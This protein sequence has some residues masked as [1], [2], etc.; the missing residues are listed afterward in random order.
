MEEKYRNQL[1]EKDDKLKELRKKEK[2]FQRIEKL[3]SKEEDINRKLKSD[4]DRMK[5]QKVVGSCQSSMKC[6]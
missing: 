4:I 3:K 5:T 6:I 1:K 2:Y